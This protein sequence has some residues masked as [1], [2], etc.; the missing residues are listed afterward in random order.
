MQPIIA[1][2]IQQPFAWLI[3]AGHKDIENRDWP[4][5]FRGPVLIHAGK[6]MY[7]G[8]EDAQDWGWPDI[9]RPCDFDLGGIVGEA[10][11][12][13]CVTESASR[14]FFGRYGFV[15]QNARLTPFRPCRGQL[16][17]FTPDFAPQPKVVRPKPVVASRQGEFF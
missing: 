10:E 9:E 8:F 6:R 11:I 1:I 7:D 2:S 3:A 12:V 13:D 5:R 16:K 14:W 17:F 4:T 15:I